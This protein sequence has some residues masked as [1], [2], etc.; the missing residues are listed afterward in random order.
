MFFKASSNKKNTGVKIGAVVDSLIDL[1]GL[2]LM[3][4]ALKN[5]GS[6]DIQ[7]GNVQL[8]LFQFAGLIKF[9]S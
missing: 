1:E 8:K 6:S 2:Y 9:L 7:C 5:A 3:V 4:L